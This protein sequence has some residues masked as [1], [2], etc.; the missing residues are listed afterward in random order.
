MQEFLPRIHPIAAFIFCIAAS[1]LYF[2]CIKKWFAGTIGWVFGLRLGDL[3][4]Y[5]VIVTDRP[6]GD[7]RIIGT[8]PLNLLRHESACDTHLEFHWLS[9][10]TSK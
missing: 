9:G 8:L 1:T 10:E 3:T 5:T 7:L 6:K 2:I 4:H